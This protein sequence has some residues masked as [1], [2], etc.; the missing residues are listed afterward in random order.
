[1]ISFVTRYFIIGGSIMAGWIN[2]FAANLNKI[3]GF[4]LT[5]CMTYLS[6]PPHRSL[7]S[8]E[9]SGLR[10]SAGEQPLTVM[11]RSKAQI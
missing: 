4:E 1:L 5:R 11:D 7:L 10:L 2:K 9:L 8:P 6:G 3:L